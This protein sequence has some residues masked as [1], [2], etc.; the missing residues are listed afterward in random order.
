M[1]TSER[2]AKLKKQGQVK[3]NENE[4]ELTCLSFKAAR[5][6]DD[7]ARRHHCEHL[8]DELLLAF[9]D[10]LETF[11]PE[12]DQGGQNDGR[13]LIESMLLTDRTICY[14]HHNAV[15]CAS[16]AAKSPTIW[17]KFPVQKLASSIA[18]IFLSWVFKQV[19][20]PEQKH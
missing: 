14:L 20:S 18:A 19:S 16:R 12:Q 9:R 13:N 6:I 3:I 15:R 5:L 8:R 10:L 2:K 7:Y 17:E 1:K 4:V 11:I